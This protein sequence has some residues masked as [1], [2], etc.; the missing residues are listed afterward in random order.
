MRYKM[1]SYYF[2]FVFFFLMAVLVIINSAPIEKPWSDALKDLWFLRTNWHDFGSGYVTACHQGRLKEQGF[3]R[4]RAAIV[5]YMYSFE[6]L[7]P[8]IQETSNK[9]AGV[10]Y[11]F[12]KL[13]SVGDSVDIV[14]YN[15][16]PSQL[17]IKGT[18]CTYIKPQWSCGGV[19]ICFLAIMLLWLAFT[20]L[21]LATTKTKR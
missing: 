19:I 2:F 3:G 4:G 11:S 14:S 9:Y 5:Y 15:N 21:R 7:E 8:P 16:D 17:K 10:C 20:V 1:N 18:Y 6:S 12:E 13:F